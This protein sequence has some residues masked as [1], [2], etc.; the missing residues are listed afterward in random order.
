MNFLYE[1]R[2]GKEEDEIIPSV[3]EEAKVLQENEEKIKKEN[4]KNKFNFLEK[5]YGYF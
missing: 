2:K 1:R 4:T 5:K 3:I